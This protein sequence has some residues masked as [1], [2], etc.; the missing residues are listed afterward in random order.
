MWLILGVCFKS[1]E[2]QQRKFLNILISGFSEC[3]QNKMKTNLHHKFHFLNR[4]KA[5]IEKN[6]KKTKKEKE[7]EESFPLRIC[8]NIENID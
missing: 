7:K 6:K 5:I 8:R 3:L 2:Q 1:K 4:K